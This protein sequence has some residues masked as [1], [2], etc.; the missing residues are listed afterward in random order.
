[1][2]D[3]Y[4]FNNMETKICY[5]C[6]EEKP[7]E[8][9]YKD[10]TRK[11]GRH[12]LCKTCSNQRMKLYY[13]KNSEEIKNRARN[14]EKNNREKRNASVKKWKDKHRDEVR[15][16]GREYYRENKHIY[17]KYRALNKD[18][19]NEKRRIWVSK[20]K[21]KVKIR[22]K[23]CFL[24]N[25]E[26]NKYKYKE[27]RKIWAQKNHDKLFKERQKK[28]IDLADRY[29]KDSLI[30]SGWDKTKLNP[31]I[32]EEKRNIIRTRRIILKINQ[33]INKKTNT[34]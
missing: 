8:E 23:E 31:D 6:G 14:W 19:L 17:D 9:F 10:K 24:R 28:I 18:I 33:S 4:S 25:Y 12:S 34:L 11:D 15:A 5:K 26:K 20:N 30:R 22:Q 2:L 13:Q 1:M 7:L 21:E 32:I 16:A 27:R 3:S 29:I